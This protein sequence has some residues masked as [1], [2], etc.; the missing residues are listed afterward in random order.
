MPIRPE[1]RERYP[2][3]WPE[4]SRSAKEAA[5][6][7][8]A[9]TGQC[10]RGTHAGRC[11]N[12]HG[13]PAYSTGSLVVLTTAHLNHQPEDCRESN[14]V[15][16]CQGCHLHHDRGHHQ[17]TAAL[18]RAV[19]LKAA[20]QLEFDAVAALAVPTEPQRLPQAVA[21]P[22]TA[23]CDVAQLSLDIGIPTPHTS[24]L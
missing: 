15:P 11:P 19:A 22:V 8:C 13:Q 6:W 14:L 7:R 4:I 20:G 23:L 12:A 18:T 3:N 2:A 5:G 10:G 17:V 21:E 24:A 16:M 1:N 9:C